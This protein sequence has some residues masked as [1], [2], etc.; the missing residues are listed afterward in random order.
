MSVVDNK[1]VAIAKIKEYF[2]GINQEGINAIM[3]N[4]QIETSFSAGNLVEQKVSWKS[5]RE[6]DDLTS[7]NKNL[8]EWAKSKG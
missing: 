1:A 2:P 5:Q 3:A 6:R 4:I 8:D 7:I